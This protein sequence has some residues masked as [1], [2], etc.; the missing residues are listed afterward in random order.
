MKK[1]ILLILCIAFNSHAYILKQGD[2]KVTMK[3]IEGFSLKIPEN[4]RLGFLSSNE[5]L[6]KTIYTIL[7]M[8]HI[9]KWGEDNGVID[10][11]LAEVKAREVFEQ[12]YQK[13]QFNFLD[14][15]QNI[16][17]LDFLK[18][19]QYYKQV[20]KHIFDSVDSAQFHELAE[21]KYKINLE[22]YKVPENRDVS[23]VSFVYTNETRDTVK[24]LAKN[25]LAR[26]KEDKTEFDKRFDE[27]K[28]SDPRIETTTFEKFEYD[29]AHKKFS[30]FIFAPKNA[31][32]IVKGIE[33]NGRFT[34]ARIDKITPERY[35][36]FDKVK[37]SIIKSIGSQN[38]EL[39]FDAL[40]KSLTSGEI[41]Y[42]QH[43][44]Q[45]VLKKYN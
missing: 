32:I 26:L 40:I 5:R 21:E 33:Y 29:K 30:E 14:E 19:E 22:L 27:E 25:F 9:A 18:L 15:T 12:R 20:Q 45:Q 4:K 34:F 23:F 6:E 13:N 36:S 11:S 7:N 42:N 35:K 38:G 17:L 37:E 3:D 31:G 2:A 43:E 28:H 24:A 41:N 10:K 44:I 8:K 16:L 39:K 1:N